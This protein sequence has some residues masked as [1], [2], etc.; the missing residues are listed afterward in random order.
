M[1]EVRITR[2]MVKNLFGRVSYNMELP[3]ENPIAIITAPN[4][5]GKT[6]LMNLIMFLFSPSEKTF[7]AIRGVPFEVFRCG[8]SNGKTVELKP[9][10]AAPAVKQSSEDI[11]VRR[12]QAA[13]DRQDYI[14]TVYDGSAPAGEPL[15]YLTLL[16]EAFSSNLAAY[17][18]NG[19]S[20]KSNAPGAQAAKIVWQRLAA[21][22]QENGCAVSVNH[23]RADRIQHVVLEGGGEEEG[24]K[25]VSPLALACENISSMIRSATDA[26]NVEVSKA[27]DEFP[28]LFLSGDRKKIRYEYF[29]AEW[30]AYRYALTQYQEIGLIPITEDFTKGADLKRL[31]DEKGDFL[32]AYLEA[33]R[34]TT[35]PLKDIY[36]RLR[37]FSEIFNERNVITRKKLLFPRGCV[38]LYENGRRMNLEIMSS[39]EKHDFMMF[40]HLIFN[41]R[42]GSL[43]LIDEPE[44]S[45]HIEWQESYIDR[46]AQICKMNS[47]QAIIATHSPHIVNGHYDY[48]VKKNAAED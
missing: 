40:Y 11:F 14:F 24:A 42:R 32:S 17:F 7:A 35:E 6:T 21:Y 1:S 47:L 10:K 31:Y 36:E 18:E 8:L 46:L 12:P 26:Y 9:E 4:G 3:E 25:T 30:N 16:N 34:K 39:G 29:E 33:F 5:M 27:K 20:G 13:P 2:I 37:L 48:L 15:R 45:L 19:K 43:V 41:S 38:T 23:V 44:I 28:R 22:L